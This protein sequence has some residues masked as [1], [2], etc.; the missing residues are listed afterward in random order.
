MKNFHWIPR[1][2][3][4]LAI[5]FVSLFAAD[6]FAPELTLWQQISGFFMHLIPSFVLL[7]ILIVSWK[8]ELLGGI[9]F[10]VIGIIFTPIVFSMNYQMNHSLATSLSVIAMITLPFIIIGVL[11]L[12]S[13]FRKRKEL[14]NKDKLPGL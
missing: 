12:I 11:F 14:R 10:I 8:R 9:I 2:L 13:Y 7:L 1:I 3:C 5:L 4:I 6:S